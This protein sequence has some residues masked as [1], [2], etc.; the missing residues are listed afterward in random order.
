MK[1]KRY[2]I[3][4]HSSILKRDVPCSIFIPANQK[5]EMPILL[6]LHASKF[7]HKTYFS[8]II[9][10]Q[11]QMERMVKMELIDPAIIITPEAWDSWYINDA[12]RNCCYEDF[13][14][15][16]F[17]PFIE[18]NLPVI[19]GSKHRHITGF[20]MGGAGALRFSLTH[21]QLFNSASGFCSAII[22]E[23]QFIKPSRILFEFY[24]QH[25]LYDAFQ[26]GAKRITPHFQKTSPIGLAQQFKT[27]PEKDVRR[28]ILTTR[29]DFAQ[30]GNIQFHNHL[31]ENKIGHQFEYTTGGHNPFAFSRALPK[32]LKFALAK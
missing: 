23:K 13:F 4:I 19:P 6:A 26:R 21:P 29:R 24:N 12:S 31:E 16:E 1:Q 30:L 3:T 27:P 15:Q 18:E 5:Q 10:L 28:L 2:T 14:I 20:S 7:H 9:K 22:T 17:I 8:P 11:K 25:K 32:I